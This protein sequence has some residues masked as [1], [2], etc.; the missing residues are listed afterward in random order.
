MEL[1]SSELKVH[2]IAIEYPGYGIYPGHPN[3][4]RIEEESL[5]VYDYINNVLGWKQ[6]NII[7]FGRSIGSGF[8]THVASNRSPGMLILMSAFTSI[9]SVANHITCIFSFMVADRLKN[10]DKISH[11]KCPKIFLH[12][13]EDTLVP[14]ENSEKLF[15]KACEPKKLL[16]FH[17]MNHNSFDLGE[18]F[19]FPVQKYW[20]ELSF[21]TVPDST[22]SMLNIKIKDLPYEYSFERAVNCS[23]AL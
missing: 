14:Y 13:I 19:S 16:I 2:T 12:G 15:M 22:H 17:G 21:S 11:V 8:A 6:S 18:H 7:I 4:D 9:K 3:A 10:L 1:V 5:N 20:S 23:C